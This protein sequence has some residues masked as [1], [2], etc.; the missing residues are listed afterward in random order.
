M[1][2]STSI[3]Q[4]KAQQPFAAAAGQKVCRRELHSSYSLAIVRWQR[5]SSAI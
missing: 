1:T 3:S 5:F 2:Q 4:E